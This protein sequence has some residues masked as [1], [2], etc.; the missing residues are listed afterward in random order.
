[1]II[2]TKKIDNE[3][4]IKQINGFELINTSKIGIEVAER[5]MDSED[6][7]LSAD[8]FYEIQLYFNDIMN[9]IFDKCEEVLNENNIKIVCE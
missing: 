8:V 1:M 4:T 9:E 2:D 6:E 3:F 5:Y 7:V